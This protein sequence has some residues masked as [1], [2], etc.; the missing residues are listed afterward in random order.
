MSNI[1]PCSLT[2]FSLYLLTYIV[3]NISNFRFH[4]FDIKPF[5]VK[6]KQHS[7][8][9]ESWRLFD[10]F[11]IFQSTVRTTILIVREKPH[12]RSAPPHLFTS[13]CKKLCTNVFKFSRL[14]HENAVDRGHKALLL[15]SMEHKRL[16]TGICHIFINSNFWLFVDIN[17]SLRPH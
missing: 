2:L 6:H 10:D 8:W 3:P 15:E 7:W 9:W 16:S 5:K 11:T 4:T 13:R 1:V 12:L 17:N 14:T